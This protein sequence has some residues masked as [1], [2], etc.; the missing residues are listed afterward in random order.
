MSATDEGPSHPDGQLSLTT[1][2]IKLPTFLTD[3]PKVWFLQAKAQFAIKCV[4]DFP[5]QVSSM[6]AALPQDVAT[7]LIDLISNPTADPYTTLRTRLIQMYTLSNFQRY[8]ALQSIPVL[9]DQRPSEL[10]DKM[11][12]L[13]PKDVKP[14]F[15]FLGL[16]MDCLPADICSHLLTEL[17]AD[18]RL[19]ATRAD[20]LWTV[21]DLRQVEDISLVSR[22]SRTRSSSSGTRSSSPGRSTSLS[23]SSE[24]W[25][26][27]NWGNQAN[28]CRSPC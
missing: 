25:Y 20:K 23:P 1:V 11:L 2:S 7:R 4:T 6:R 28:Q 24:C 9:T 19:M 26:H 8:Q 22:S 16:F 5:D 13:L 15:F 21:Q 18:P 3:S 17:I 27:R 10:M 14:G 12:V